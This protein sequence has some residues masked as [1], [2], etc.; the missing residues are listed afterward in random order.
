MGQTLL[1]CAKKEGA[2]FDI[3]SVLTF[4]LP[5]YSRALFSSNEATELAKSF[6]MKRLR[7]DLNSNTLDTRLMILDNVRLF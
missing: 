3:Q 6:P 1:A 2:K 7:R 4:E 5:M